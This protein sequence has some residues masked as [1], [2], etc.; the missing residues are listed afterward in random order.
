MRAQVSFWFRL[1]PSRFEMARW[2]DLTYANRQQGPSTQRFVSITLRAIID[3]DKDF[4]S[5]PSAHPHLVPYKSESP[6]ET[7]QPLVLGR[8]PISRFCGFL[9]VAPLPQSVYIKPS[10][11]CPQKLIYLSSTI[12]VLR[13]GHCVRCSSPRGIV[14]MRRKAV[15]RPCN[16]T[17]R[18]VRIWCCSTW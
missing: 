16:A 18:G 6:P 5:R 3:S 9:W 8:K 10:R 2:R 1:D 7:T 14:W 13:D 17:S 12:P 15:R 4:R 11:S